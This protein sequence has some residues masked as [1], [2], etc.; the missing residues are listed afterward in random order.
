MK[1][2][3]SRIVEC[4]R[5]FAARDKP[6]IIQESDKAEYRKMQ[7]PM[8]QK[9]HDPSDKDGAGMATESFVCILGSGVC[10][11][12]QA[13]WSGRSRRSKRICLQP[14]WPAE[15]LRLAPQLG[16]ERKVHA[17]LCG[18]PASGDQP[19]QEQRRATSA[20]TASVCLW[21]T[22]TAFTESHT[23]ASFLLPPLK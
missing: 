17:T 20:S 6:E 19:N 2:L 13:T 21:F 1:I 8:W 22:E 23:D 11:G 18:Q 3:F 9:T 7:D 5:S 12:M 10:G 16:W 4:R 14:L 15:H